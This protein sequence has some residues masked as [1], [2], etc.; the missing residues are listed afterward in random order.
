MCVRACEC[1]RTQGCEL[2][3]A[4]PRLFFSP[5]FGSFQVLLQVSSEPCDLNSHPVASAAFLPHEHT[6]LTRPRQHQVQASPRSAPWSEP[7][8]PAR[9]GRG[10]RLAHAGS[11]VVSLLKCPSFLDLLENTLR[12]PRAWPRR[13]RPLAF[14]PVCPLPAFVGGWV[15]FLQAASFPFTVVLSQGS[16]QFLLSWSVSS[17]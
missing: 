11:A 13:L 3:S 12:L 2:Q 1:L 14:H 17:P 16:C 9:P 8:P 15:S 4:F 6:P 10:V 5:V 7:F